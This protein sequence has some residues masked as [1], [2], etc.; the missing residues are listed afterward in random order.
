[1][2]IIPVNQSDVSDLPQFEAY[3]VTESITIEK[4]AAQLNVDPD[5]LRYF[6]HLEPGDE[7]MAK[8]WIIVPREKKNTQ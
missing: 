6:N 5:Q 1:V 7:L 3:Q 4:M 8:E 2:V